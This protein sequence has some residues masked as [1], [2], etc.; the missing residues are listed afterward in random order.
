MYIHSS[1][2]DEEVIANIGRGMQSRDGERFCRGIIA[3]SQVVTSAAII[4]V[5]LLLLLVARHA[6]A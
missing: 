2:D 4:S 5:R 3:A 6:N 1:A